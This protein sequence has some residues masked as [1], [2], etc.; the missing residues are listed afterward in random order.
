MN[1]WCEIYRE[2][3]ITIKYN[4][5]FDLKVVRSNYRITLRNRF[6]RLIK[7]K[8]KKKPDEPWKKVRDIVKIEA[9]NKNIPALQMKI[10]SCNKS[11]MENK[12]LGKQGFVTSK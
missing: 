5:S 6:S 10:I 9:G 12:G 3:C 11:K 4:G 7:K 2:K 1:E 8:K